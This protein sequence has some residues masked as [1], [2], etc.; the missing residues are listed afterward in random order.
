MVVLDL[1][2][3]ISVNRLRRINWATQK[4]ASTWRD[5]ADRHL[6]M[7]KVRKD[8]PVRLL[9]IQRFELLIVLSEE[10]VLLDLDN[11]LKLLIDYLRHRNIIE[12]DGP[13]HMRRLTVEWGHAPEG[14]RV[15]ITPI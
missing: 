11:S 10:T 1:P 15:T 2:V 4:S 8:N 5:M 13:K 3:P 14:V 9:S 12:D 6:L 7:A